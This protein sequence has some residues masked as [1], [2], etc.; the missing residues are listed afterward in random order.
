MGQ[1]PWIPWKSHS[2]G[3]ERYVG[4]GCRIQPYKAGLS[5][6][7][8]RLEVILRGPTQWCVQKFEEHQVTMIEIGDVKE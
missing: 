3:Q 4:Y 6:C 8:A 5:K 1:I 2:H 7:E